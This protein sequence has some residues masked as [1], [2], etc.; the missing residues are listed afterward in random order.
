MATIIPFLK[1]QYVF[2]PEQTQAM[3]NAFDKA[4][5]ALN[6]SGNAT[7]ERET[8]AMRIIEWAR[9]GLRDPAHLCEQVLRDS[10]AA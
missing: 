2:E 3:S 8:L 9:R 6:L 5:A 7:Y 1:D 10:R 4:C